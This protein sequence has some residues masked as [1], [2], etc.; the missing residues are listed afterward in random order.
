[1]QSGNYYD[2]LGIPPTASKED[3]KKAYKRLAKIYHPDINRQ[4]NAGLH[5]LMVRQAYETLFD[6]TSRHV[7]DQQIQRGGPA[8]L[9][10]EQ[11]KAIE[12]RRQEELEAKIHEAFLAKKKK[13]QD[14]GYVKIA[15]IGLYTAVFLSYFTAITIVIITLSLMWYHHWITFFW[16]LPLVCLATYLF[17]ATPHWFKEQKRFFN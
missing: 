11:W 6:P 13:F 7:Y 14:S 2:I 10:Y 5:F 17:F 1:M 12:K 3:I 15:H 8:L 16:M 4:A 9:T